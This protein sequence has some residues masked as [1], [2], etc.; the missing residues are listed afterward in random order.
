MQ[1]EQHRAVAHPRQAG[2]EAA[3][4][5]LQLM[6]LAHLALDL[7]PLHAEGRIGQHV[8]ELALGM[9]VVAERVAADD[10]GHVL[11]LDQHVG[12]ADREGLVVE[13]LAEHGQARLRVVRQQMLGR[14][15]QHAAGAGGRVVDGA[16]HRAAGRQHLAV[17]DEQQV[18]HQPDHL[19]RGE[20][21]AGRLVGD[22][23]EL[24]DQLLEDAAH[25]GVVDH[26]RVQ[27][28]AG[29]LLGDQIEQIGLGQ[30]LDLAGEV[31]ALEDVARRR[32]EG[33][34]IGVEVLADVVL[35]AQERGQVQRA[36]VVEAH[37]GLAQQEGLGVQP[38]LGARR[39]LG[40]H[41]RLGGLQHAVQPAQHG[42]G[43]DDAAVFALLV[44]TTQQV[45]DRPDE[46]REGL[47][48]HSGQR[49]SDRSASGPGDDSRGP[50]VSAARGCPPA[51]A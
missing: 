14:H 15:R 48:I 39:M 19:A 24:A 46:G 11:A 13:F 12:L 30:A 29:E 20:V 9:A 7:L 4:E 47:G 16:H 8:V 36:G 22:F 41:R 43:Q 35:V 25:R 1:Q 44:V 18:H 23:G 40:Q 2:A 33:L 17:L 10:V 6:L 3:V 45:G 21:L 31:E 38:G 32:R 51:R 50:G 42:E 27:I 37:A 5:A 49:R 26:V 34:Q 28:D